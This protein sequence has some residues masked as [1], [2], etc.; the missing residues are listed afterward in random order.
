[1]VVP[2]TNPVHNHKENHKQNGE[3]ILGRSGV[4][5]LSA[6]FVQKIFSYDKYLAIYS[7][8]ALRKAYDLSDFKQNWCTPLGRHIKI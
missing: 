5:L 2:S 6:A 1:V 4:L 7:P 8:D 3:Y